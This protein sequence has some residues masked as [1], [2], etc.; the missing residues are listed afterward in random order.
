MRLE[1][2]MTIIF[3]VFCN[4]ILANFIYNAQEIPYLAGYILEA[5]FNIAVGMVLMNYISGGIVN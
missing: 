5:G 4:I 3:V 1:F 2:I